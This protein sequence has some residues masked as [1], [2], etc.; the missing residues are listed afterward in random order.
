MKFLEGK[1]VKRS[2][3]N[4]T[5]FLLPSELEFAIILILISSKYGWKIR[6]QPF[7]YLN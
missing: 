2:M 5:Q 6:V 4:A 7:C 1:G 3:S